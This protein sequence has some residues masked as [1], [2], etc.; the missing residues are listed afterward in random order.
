MKLNPNGNF[1]RW[2]SQKILSTGIQITYKNR[3]FKNIQKI[4]LQVQSS[5]FAIFWQKTEQV[6]S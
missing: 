3:E 1:E 2:P 4:L 6:K 5:K